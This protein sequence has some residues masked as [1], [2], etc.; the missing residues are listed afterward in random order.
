MKVTPVRARFSGGGCTHRCTGQEGSSPCRCGLR[1][2]AERPVKQA[3]AGVRGEEGL[4]R[5]RRQGRRAAGSWRGGGGSP[6]HLQLWRVGDGAVHCAR[7]LGHERGGHALQWLPEGAARVCACGELWRRGSQAAAARSSIQRAM[8][9]R[10]LLLRTWRAL[11]SPSPSLHPIFF[12]SFSAKVMPLV[13]SGPAGGSA[14]DPGPG[15][16]PAGGRQQRGGGGRLTRR[17]LLRT[18]PPAMA[19][20]CTAAWHGVPLQRSALPAPHIPRPCRAAGRLPRCAVPLA[21]R[22]PAAPPAAPP[23]L[24]RARAAKASSPLMAR[25]LE[26]SSALPAHAPREGGRG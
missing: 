9:P 20:M 17:A 21:A 14:L 5:V 19:R 3:G 6:A 4:G 2:G 18:K 7:L 22:S 26:R 1:A 11:P 25:R 8:H 16:A 15:P 24:S 12:S 10:L 13:D 23:P